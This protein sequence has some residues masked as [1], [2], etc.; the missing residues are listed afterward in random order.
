MKAL[1]L[2]AIVAMAFALPTAVPAAAPRCQEGRFLLA[3]QPMLVAGSASP[4]IDAVV[5]DGGTLAVASGCPPIAVKLQRQGRSTRIR[6]AWPAG[7]CAGVAGRVRLTGTINPTCE[8]MRGKLV[9]K[10]RARRFTARRSACGDGFLD[11]EG[12]EVCPLLEGPPAARA[13]DAVFDLDA[14]TPIPATAYDRNAHGAALVRTRIELA[15]AAD[16]TVEQVNTL[17][18]RVGGRIVS[19]VGGVPSVVLDIPD[20]GSVAA[21]DALVADLAAQP[22]VRWVLEA[23]EPVPTALPANFTAPL[24]GSDAARL[25]H[26]LAVRAAAAWNA[27]GAMGETPT[28]AVLD[29]FGDGPPDAAYDLAVPADDF[30]LAGIGE[31]GTHGYH[32]LGII[33]ASFGGANTAR[34]QA[35]GMVPGRTRARVIDMRDP[36]TDFLTEMNRTV[37]RLKDG[38]PHGVLNTSLGGNCGTPL[39]DLEGQATHWIDKV[40]GAGLEDRVLHV[41]AAG[42]IMTGC[43]GEVAAQS[44]GRFQAAAL[45]PLSVPNLTNMLVIENAT[46]TPGPEF[47]PSCRDASSKFPGHLAGIGTDVF[48]LKGAMTNAGDKT[49]TSMATPQVAGLAAYL[50]ALAPAMTVQELRGLLLA[51]A[52]PVVTAGLGCDSPAPVI[53]AY[54][55]VLA[56]DDAAPPD[57]VHAPIRQAILDADDS[58]RF[59]D[60]DL[61]AFVDAFIDPGTGDPREPAQPD[62]GR[63]DLNGDGF[64][65]G[66][67]RKAPFD[68]DRID[69]VRY[70]ESRYGVV[71]QTIGGADVPFSEAQ[72]TDLDVLCYYAYSDL[73]EGSA[74]AREA[75]LPLAR[76]ARARIEVTLA[77]QM[78]AGVATAL[79]VQVKGLDHDGLA[80]APLAGVYVELEPSGGTVGT[81]TGL[82]DAEG[83]FGTTATANAGASHFDVDIVV[84]EKPGG[85]ILAETS[86]QASVLSA[87]CPLFEPALHLV[88]GGS[89]SEGSD[90]W[91]NSGQ[92]LHDALDL[93]NR[94]TEASVS[95]GTAHVVAQIDD[96]SHPAHEGIVAHGQF[97]DTI[98]VTADESRF[99]SGGG[100]LIARVEVTA[101]G[102]ASG[103]FM[104]ANWSLTGL[105]FTSSRV[106]G[107]YTKDG[108]TGDP[109]GVHELP[110]RVGVTQE[111]GIDFLFDAGAG[112]GNFSTSGAAAIDVT[113][114]VLGY[115]DLR[116]DA[117]ESVPFELCSTF[118]RLSPT[119]TTTTTSTS[120]TTTTTS[121]TSTSTTTSTTV[122]GGDRDPYRLYAATGPDGPSVTLA[123]EFRTETV[124]LGSILFFLPPAGI[125]GISF[126]DQTIAQACYDHTGATFSGTANVLHRLGSQTLQVGDPVALCVPSEASGIAVNA[127][128]C[129]AATGDSLAQAHTL[130]DPFQTEAI[131]VLAPVLFCVPVDVN[132]TGI[133]NPLEYL[134]C[135]QTT[136]PGTA[137]GQVAIDNPFHQ[138]T[139]DAGV[140]NGICLPSLATAT[141]GP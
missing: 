15:F 66:A 63:Y 1:F 83:R 116:D 3:G 13:F 50:W 130:A 86:A 6:A 76:C 33:A 137:A 11:R 68:L 99:P 44:D 127:Y 115:V 30:S 64:T 67:Q 42:N 72:A 102:S 96:A 36:A 2:L 23:D 118:P 65:G 84:R 133:V 70:G 38:T 39:A 105:A 14:P 12:G 53:D 5:L 136:P 81:A 101:S 126:L 97:G 52:E 113:F 117:G 110:L 26:H 46:N 77:A 108:Y 93:G 124:N 18:G 92:T 128:A 4:A 54:A 85:R 19:M 47:A 71:L 134:T 59:D 121:T 112:S 98:R 74:A 24:G 57:P 106:L 22:G 20:P 45:L 94:R 37:Q 135:Y 123:D 90:Q 16:A 10:K 107:S 141:P 43:P 95:M 62:Y 111:Q 109:L 120:T 129:H 32:V 89:G 51:T 29:F 55:A 48:S 25:D 88:V 100:W 58:G 119:T 140:P 8:R 7:T 56:L 17:I 41:A 61:T 114:R 35:T 139:V 60:A 31:S 34:G 21:L 73:F 131:Q 27:R 82:T 75:A 91:G 79:D 138:T 104:I 103:N 69:S 87:D 80:L 132:S 28:V 125:D 122:P 40:R 9:V 78:T 49:G